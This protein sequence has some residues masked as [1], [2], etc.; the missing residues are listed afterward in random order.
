M[1][2]VNQ[3]SLK[4]F[5]PL[6]LRTFCSPKMQ[7]QYASLYE[8]LGVTVNAT[9]TE[10]KSAYLTKSK[11]FHPDFNMESDTNLEFLKVQ[12]AYKTLSNPLHRCAYDRAFTS[13]NAK[14]MFH[15][16][17][18]TKA[19]TPN[20]WDYCHHFH[21]SAELS[22]SDPPPTKKQELT[23][24]Q[25]FY[26]KNLVSCFWL[27]IFLGT[28]ALLFGTGY[29]I[30]N[31]DKKLPETPRKPSHKVQVSRIWL[32]ECICKPVSPVIV[33]DICDNLRRG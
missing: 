5:R 8:V 2:K 23:K 21:H 1:H 14:E 31:K 6:K 19:Q 22:C 9:Q 30:E 17:F 15:S 33:T 7:L 24:V 32:M 4:M 10:I 20:V 26:S 28:T 16:I 13:L 29:A 11:K 18:H 3:K 27:I 12:N 25:Q